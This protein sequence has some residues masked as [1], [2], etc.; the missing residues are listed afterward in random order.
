MPQRAVFDCMLSLQAVTRDTGPA[1]RCFELVEQGKVT[2]VVCPAILAEVQDVLTRPALVKKFP[3]LTPERVTAFIKKF[4]AVAIEHPD[5]PLFFLL[6]RDPDD[7]P[8]INLA[9]TAE[10]QFLVT[11]N[12]RHLTYL[13]RQDTPEGADFC[14]RFPKI[15]IVPPPQF[16]QAVTPPAQGTP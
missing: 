2:L 4:R 15:K 6:P 13:M 3:V 11:W 12:E 10:A 1:F 14:Q 8:Y 16:I 9:I 5:P 7:Q